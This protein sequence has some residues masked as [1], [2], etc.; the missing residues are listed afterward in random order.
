MS[1]LD[2]SLPDIAVETNADLARRVV[3]SITVAS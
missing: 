1:L 2:E 3:S